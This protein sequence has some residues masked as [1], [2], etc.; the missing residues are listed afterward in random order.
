MVRDHR[1]SIVP[2]PTTSSVARA[3]PGAGAGAG[4]ASGCP[5]GVAKVTAAVLFFRAV[6]Y[7]LPIPLE[8]ALWTLPGSHQRRTRPKQ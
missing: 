4:A 6:T 5:S 8:H 2:G 7:L 1:G 3:Q